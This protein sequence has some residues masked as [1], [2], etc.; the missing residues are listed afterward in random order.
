MYDY[1]N[2]KENLEDLNIWYKE[3]NSS[4]KLRPQFLSKIAVIELC[5]WTE[6]AMDDIVFKCADKLLS[7]QNKK[8]VEELMGRV[9]GFDYR[10]HFLKMLAPIIG[11]ISVQDVELNLDQGKFVCLCA[12]LADLKTIRDELAHT[13]IAGQM[14]RLFAPSV[15]LD[16]FIKIYMGLV[17]YENVLISKGYL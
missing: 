13:H 3:P 12:A 4:N 6:E 5:G 9:H 1:T 2:I 14:P 15:T 11:H 7:K 17:D 8:D 10:Q 16:Y